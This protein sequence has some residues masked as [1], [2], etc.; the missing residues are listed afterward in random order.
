MYL[1]TRRF[2]WA[3][4][5]LSGWAIAQ[6]DSTYIRM[7]EQGIAP[8][9]VPPPSGTP[10]TLTNPA[11]DCP[12]AIRICQGV[13][14]FTAAVPNFG[15]TQELPGGLGTCLS[16][17]EHRSVWFTFTIQQSGTLGFIIDPG[18]FTDYDFALWNVTGLSNPC[19]AIG[20]IAPI[21]CNFS[22]N[23]S[24]T[25]CCG[26][27]N[28]GPGITGMDHTNIQ[29]GTV[30]H[31][32]GGAPVMPGMNVTAG[33]TFLLLVDN[34]T[35]NNQGYTITFTG[36]AQ[37]F[38]NSPPRMDSTYQVCATSY[39]HQVDYLRQ[40]VV[41]FSEFINPSTVAPNGSDFVVQDVATSTLVPVTAAAPLSS[42]QTNSIRLTLGAPLTPGASYK[43]RIGY[44]PPGSGSPNGQPGS[45]GNTISDQC[46]VFIP[47]ANIPQGS[48]ADSITHVVRDTLNPTVSIVSPRCIGTPTGSI[49]VTTTGGASPYQYILVS[50]V[51]GTPP[52][53]GWSSTST[54][55]NRSAGTY[56]IWIRDAN[57]CIIRR[58][59]QL[60]DPPPLSMAVTD[61]N[62]FV[63]G[64]FLGS[65]TFVGQGGTPPYEYSLLPTSPAWQT[66]N[67]FTGLSAN[68]Y[69]LRVRDAN[70]CTVTR[71]FTVQNSPPLNMQVVSTTPIPCAGG[72]GGFT[73]QALG[74]PTGTYTYTLVGPG[75]QNTSGAFNGLS[76][77]TYI[78]QAQ[79]GGFCGTTQVSLTEPTP[80]ALQDSLITPVTCRGGQD[81]QIQVTVTGGTLP[82]TYTWQSGTGQPLPGNTPNLSGLS[83]GTY[84]VLITDNNGCTLGPRSYTVSYAN[85]TH[86]DNA[87]YQLV[88]D[89]PNKDYTFSISVRGNGPFLYRWTWED[90]TSQVGGAVMSRTFSPQ[91]QGAVTIRVQIEGPGPC[92]DDTSITFISTACV[93]LLIPNVITPNG[94]GINDVW[95]IQAIGFS[96]YK[97]AIFDRW[98]REVFNNGGN[99]NSRW[100]G[101]T[102][103]QALPEGVYSYLFD[104]DRLDGERVVRTG[105]VTLLR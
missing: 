66:S 40:L 41:R 18:A 103:G 61:S 49:S 95:N 27:Y 2:L 26:G 83:E 79:D 6:I 16:G 80:L 78:V 38:D 63:C 36:T 104:G 1:S 75:T 4:L 90:G 43:V 56:T 45:D 105:T 82:Y 35:N 20:T 100:D 13:Y 28:G 71:S 58:I 22:A 3:A 92:Y 97:V 81:G 14:N 59:A 5:L 32:A 93:G 70:G 60:V 73:V 53:S 12:G 25:S 52:A 21:R 39:D 77:G 84:S 57:G 54:W 34:W 55:P 99:Q 102:N 29:A 19:S 51:S 62:T 101:T 47:V 50:G 9:Y 11:S 67:T 44:N 33:Q 48:S 98:G 88:A 15:N 42:P 64:S 10:W 85:E 37:Y 72:T 23:S 94:D 96:R 65:V 31:G 89:C 87:F 76:A 7:K 8:P 86:I 17:G 68:T 74:G 91:L 30:T 24:T 46:G 69:T